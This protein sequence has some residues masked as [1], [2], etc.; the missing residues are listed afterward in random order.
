MSPTPG[1]G[2]V[3]SPQP[4]PGPAPPCMLAGTSTKSWVCPPLRAGTSC[5][6]P[7]GYRP[8]SC[9]QTPATELLTSSASGCA[10][11]AAWHSLSPCV[12]VNTPKL[13]AIHRPA[14]RARKVPFGSQLSVQMSRMLPEAATQA[15]TRRA[16]NQSL[17]PHSH[18]PA[19]RQ[20]AAPTVCEALVGR[21]AAPAADNC[22]RFRRMQVC[23]PRRRLH[24]H[25]CLVFSTTRAQCSS[26]FKSSTE[27]TSQEHI[28]IL[29]R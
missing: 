13:A 4:L 27:L 28:T 22:C 14:P 23:W 24:A 10:P 9:T 15:V 20:I 17:P 16:V 2:H 21:S 8:R 11:Y 26:N 6:Q 29:T 19:K 25:G 12:Y 18:V 1:R 3:A 7:T 5:R